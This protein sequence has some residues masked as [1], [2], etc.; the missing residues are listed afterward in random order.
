MRECVQAP[1]VSASVSM[2]VCASVSLFYRMRSGESKPYMNAQKSTV[3]AFAHLIAINRSLF[4]V[5]KCNKEIVWAFDIMDT[6]VENLLLLVKVRI[7][8]FQCTV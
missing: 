1:G 6:S 2:C 5:L 8:A 3:F 4:D 7:K